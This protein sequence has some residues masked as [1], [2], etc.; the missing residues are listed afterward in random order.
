[1]EPVAQREYIQFMKAKGTPV[2][3]A[4]CSLFVDKTYPWLTSFPDGLMRDD[5]SAEKFGVL[6]DQVPFFIRHRM[7][8][9]GRR[10]ILF[11]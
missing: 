5:H 7:Q 9:H 8:P 10:N 3:V 4:A 2:N 11:V 6:G 1:M